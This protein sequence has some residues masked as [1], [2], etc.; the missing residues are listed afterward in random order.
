MNRMRAL[1]VLCVLAVAVLAVAGCDWNVVNGNQEK[2]QDVKCSL[3]PGSHDQVFDCGDACCGWASCGTP[4]MYSDY[5]AC[6]TGCDDAMYIDIVDNPNQLESYKNC[7]LEC[8]ESC[9]D[10]DTCRET[11]SALYPPTL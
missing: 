6:V 8:I 10:N 5:E 9:T 4:A 7:V 2:E 3:N 11:C 1:V